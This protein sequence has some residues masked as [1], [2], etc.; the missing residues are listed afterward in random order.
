MTEEELI[1]LGFDQVHIADAES[2]NGYDYYFYQKEICDN[3]A[4]Y[5]TDSMDVED[6]NWT[7]KC[8]D[9]PA[10]RIYSREHYMQ[11]LEVINNI[12]C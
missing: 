3:V 10:I 5:S 1:D 9:I 7:I 2:Q 6:N 4:L 12:T 8:W 11:F